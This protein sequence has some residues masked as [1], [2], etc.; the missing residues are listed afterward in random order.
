MKLKRIQEFLNENFEII[1]NTS[2]EVK[3]DDLQKIGN[4]TN[5]NKIIREQIKDDSIQGVYIWSR[6]DNDE[7]LY[8]G[9][10]GKLIWKNERK[11]N[12]TKSSYSIRKR[13]ISSRGKYELSEGAGKTE[14]TTHNYLNKILF[15]KEDI[16]SMN[17][18]VFEVEINKYSPTYIEAC[19]LQEIYEKERLIPKFNKSF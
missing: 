11:S 7:I 2:F 15:P 6:S 19:V 9:M 14:L 18:S 13:L 5:Y 8:V 12:I 1:T 16:K 10:S 3:T 4:T 17:I